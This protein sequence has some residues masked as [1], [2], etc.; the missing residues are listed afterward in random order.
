VIDDAV[1]EAIEM[2]IAKGG[3]VEFVEDGA[4]AMH[5]RIALILRY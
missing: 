3:N 2:T 5:G 4:L 1:D